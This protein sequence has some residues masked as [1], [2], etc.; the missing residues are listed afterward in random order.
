MLGNKERLCDR[1]S[2]ASGRSVRMSLEIFGK[3]V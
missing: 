2:D 1:I 3:K